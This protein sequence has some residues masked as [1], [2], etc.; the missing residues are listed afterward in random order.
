MNPIE[1][2]GIFQGFESHGSD[3]QFPGKRWGR[4]FR[5]IAM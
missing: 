5:A 2:D 1:G 3:Q 4:H